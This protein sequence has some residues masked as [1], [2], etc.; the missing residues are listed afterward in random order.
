MTFPPCIPHRRVGPPRSCCCPSPPFKLSLSPTETCNLWPPPPALCGSLSMP[1]A[2]FF[3]W[4][5]GREELLHPASLTS[6][7]CP[8]LPST[9]VDTAASPSHRV[10]R[11]TNLISFYRQLAFSYQAPSLYRNN[12]LTILLGVPPLFPRLQ[13]FLCWF[14]TNLPPTSKPDPLPVDINC[15]ISI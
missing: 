10:P 14:S 11:Q 12:P 5:L 6:P 13:P 2:H 7:D 8:H 4:S 3:A 15:F 1:H 9:D